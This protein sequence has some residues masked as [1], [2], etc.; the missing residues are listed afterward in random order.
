MAASP[1]KLEGAPKSARH[2]VVPYPYRAEELPVTWLGVINFGIVKPTICQM[3][4]H[5]VVK[6]K[7]YG[8]RSV[9]QGSVSVFARLLIRFFVFSSFEFSVFVRSVFEFFISVA[10][11]M[12][13]L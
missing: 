5:S 2:L 13:P 9:S 12:A 8:T 3:R 4:P 7:V 11:L 1:V 10:F 6:F